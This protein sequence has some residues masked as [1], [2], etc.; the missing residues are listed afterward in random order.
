MT[1]T[2]T[3]ESRDR[4]KT[5]R[6]CDYPGC[7]DATTVRD[8]RGNRYCAT[9]HLLAAANEKEPSDLIEYEVE[10]DGVTGTFRETSKEAAERQWKHHILSERRNP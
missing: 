10:Y 7:D 3:F 6:T 5:E 1:E 4:N 9:D 8:G 2:T